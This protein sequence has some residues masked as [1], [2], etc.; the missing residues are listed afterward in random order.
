MRENNIEKFNTN[1]LFCLIAMS[2]DTTDVEIGSLTV[3]AEDTLEAAKKFDDEEN[4]AGYVHHSGNV[5]VVGDGYD[6]SDVRI[7][8]NGCKSLRVALSKVKQLAEDALVPDGATRIVSFIDMEGHKIVLP[9]DEE[10]EIV[11]EE[12][13]SDNIE[14]LYFD[15]DEITV[16]TDESS[17]NAGTNKNGF[18][19]QSLE[20]NTVDE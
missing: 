7:H 15:P 18:Y 14:T 17:W 3:P 5:F 6:D 13:T 11:D 12:S 8:Y 9:F 1:S 16:I 20:L 10:F 2:N 19:F 4:T